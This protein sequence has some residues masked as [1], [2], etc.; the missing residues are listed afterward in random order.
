M[1]NWVLP[2]SIAALALTGC[3]PAPPNP[4]F[5]RVEVAQVFPEPRCPPDR[6]CVEVRARVAG[7]RI[8]EG[9]CQIFGPS[10]T[11]RQVPLAEENAL[12]MRPSETAVWSTQVPSNFDVDA[13][14]VICRPMLDG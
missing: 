10:D 2:L 13:L 3:G 9:T 4:G 11:E 1:G 12:E 5:E 6:S 7:S 14:Q 8:G